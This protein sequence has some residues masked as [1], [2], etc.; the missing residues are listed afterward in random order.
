MRNKI[1]LATLTIC[2]SYATFAQSK[3]PVMH[4]TN[5]SVAIQEDNGPVQNNRWTIVPTEKLDVMT[6][7]A[8]TIAFI[9]DKEK[10]VFTVDR[11]SPTNF[12]IL[13]NGKD[14]CLTQ[15]KYAPSRKDILLGG[16]NFNTADKRET[17]AFTYQ[18][19]SNERLQYIRK[20]Y[21]L[22]SI[23]GTGTAQ[24]KMIH[25]MTWVHNLIRHDGNSDNPNP[26]NA[27]AIINVCKKE[28][29]G[30]NCRMLATVLNEC[31]LA[32]GLKSRYV[33][34]M[35]KELQFDDCHVIN[36]V[37]DEETNKW[38]WMDPTNNAYVMNEKGELLGIREVRERLINN[39]PLILNPDANWNRKQTATVDS[40]LKQY[41]T[42]NLYRLESPA[43]SEVDFETWAKGK[44]VTFIQ[45]L[46]LDALNQTPQKSSKTYEKTG[47]TFHNY[48]TNNPDV[49]FAKP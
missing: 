43:S 32:I 11:K 29:R 20:L 46:P 19:A 3:L 25:L 40:Y 10:K 6:T 13:L 37:Y 47:T 12:Y 33:T 48:V 27:E 36:M 41:M 49:F 2:S 38:V 9:T 8:K 14:S 7:S 24:S 28:N 21:N 18:P 39:Q 23:A 5:V 30:V 45:L 16:K 26:R 44:E 15:I 31:Y 34:C 35:P 4:A 22:D 17:P 42:K 1:L